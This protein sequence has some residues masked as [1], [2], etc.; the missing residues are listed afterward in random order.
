MQLMAKVINM[1]IVKEILKL[2]L[3]LKSPHFQFQLAILFLSVVE[4][5]Y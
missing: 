4:S 2:P 1:L 3:F 5:L